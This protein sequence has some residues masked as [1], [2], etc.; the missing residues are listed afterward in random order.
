[1][2]HSYV[3]FPSIRQVVHGSG[4]TISGMIIGEFTVSKLPDS[5]APGNLRSRAISG[6]LFSMASHAIRL[7]IQLGTMVLLSRL[8]SP[9]EYG[10]VAMVLPFVAL[11]VLLQE[12]GVPMVTIMQQDITPEQ[13][14]DLFWLNVALSAVLGTLLAVCAPLVAG[15][16]DDERL[17][18]IVYAFAAMMIPAAIS[19]QHRS[20]LQRSMNFRLLAGIDIVNQFTAAALTVVAAWYG[21]GYWALILQTACLYL[22]QIP[23]LWMAY[24]WRPGRP[25]GFSQ[26]RHL[27]R[28]GGEF[29]GFNILNFFSRYLDNVLIGKISGDVALGLY[30]RAYNLMLTP[31]N[32]INAPLGQVATPLLS[33]L[34]DDPQR[35]R[36][37]YRQ[38]VEKL[39]LITMPGIVVLMAAA[40]PV[41]VMM[42]GPTWRDV[43]PI[44]SAL[45]LAA[46]VQPLNNST[47]WLFISQGRSRDMLRWGLISSPL[48][49]A[50]FVVGLPWGPVGVA[51]SY[52]AVNLLV[53]TPVLWFRVGSPL[54]SKFDAG[55]TAFPFAIGCLLSGVPLFLAQGFMATLHPVEAVALALAWAYMAQLAVL[56]ALPAY[57]HVVVGI[58]RL[59]V[60][61]LRPLTRQKKQA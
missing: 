57:R 38:T 39:L 31:I 18:L 34:V 11:I 44:L 59:A 13:A 7:F 3:V 4:L 27:V 23:L 46:V 37:A 30:G 48:M 36:S 14:S 43:A 10:L 26:V 55:V 35:Y 41:T 1:M 12:A 51:L 16:Y 29:A 52:A 45:A 5:A 15:F 21:M 33:R 50:S 24:P 20:L 54:F 6:G 47:S 22:L 40:E 53:I 32:Q 60:E 25:R 2:A 8:L 19:V 17:L 49:V 9:G 61:V 58:V 42:L 28:A 56:L